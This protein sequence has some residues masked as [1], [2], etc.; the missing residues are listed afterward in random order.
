MEDCILSFQIMEFPVSLSGE[1][2]RQT[3]ALESLL[4]WRLVSKEMCKIASDV[5]QKRY[6]RFILVWGV[7][8]EQCEHEQEREDC[9]PRFFA[10]RRSTFWSKEVQCIDYGGDEI[11]FT[12]WKKAAEYWPDFVGDCIAVCYVSNT[13]RLLNRQ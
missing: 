2:V 3:Q 4:T 11:Q 8:E 6:T 7:G 5:V 9:R 12:S 13:R 1:I 10:I